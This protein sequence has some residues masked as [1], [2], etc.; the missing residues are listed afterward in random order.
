MRYT[1]AVI[2]IYCY[3]LPFGR[4][5]ILCDPRITLS[6]ICELR[7]R[8]VDMAYSMRLIKATTI[9]WQLRRNAILYV[10]RVVIRLAGSSKETRSRGALWARRFDFF[11]WCNGKCRHQTSIQR[12]LK[13]IRPPIPPAWL[14]IVVIVLLICECIRDC[15]T[16]A[17][18]VAPL[19][20]SL[21]CT[22]LTGCIRLQSI[23]ILFHDN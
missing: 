1:F 19:K 16:H 2:E 3:Y 11:V 15:I 18:S 14:S 13:K 5:V 22:R 6:R 7:T 17:S 4:A 10:H 23:W 20:S 12:R 21:A 8:V 9:K